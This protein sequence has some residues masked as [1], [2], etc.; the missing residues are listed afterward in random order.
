MVN[1]EMLNFNMRDGRRR[2]N[3]PNFLTPWGFFTQ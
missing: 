2:Y 3:Y 1:Q